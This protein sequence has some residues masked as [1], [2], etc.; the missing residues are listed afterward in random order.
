MK[1]DETQKTVIDTDKD[2]I[3]EEKVE[4]ANLEVGDDKVSETLKPAKVL[5]EKVKVVSVPKYGKKVVLEVKH[6]DIDDPEK[7]IEL[8]KVKYLKD[9][10]LETSGTWLNRNTDGTIIGN[11]ALGLMLKHF[12]KKI[13]ELVGDQIDTVADD[14]GYLV[15]KAY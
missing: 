5:V 8:S 9:D 11:S 13:T 4:L 10:K 6:P 2:E 3:V 7:L 12:G 14:K 15:I 1:N